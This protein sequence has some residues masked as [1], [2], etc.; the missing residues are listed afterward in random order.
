[1]KEHYQ[2]ETS[3]GL[4]E[5]FDYAKRHHEMFPVTDYH[6]FSWPACSVEHRR[7]LDIGDIYINAAICKTCSWF[8]RSRNRHDF[9][10]CRCGALSVD[11][12][13]HYCKRSGN[14]DAY[15]DVI[16]MFDNVERLN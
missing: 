7:K 6:D 3:K 2:K 11:G 10:S 8:V 5:A 15:E 13:S 14:P 12:G 9:V 1:M 4:Q 16:V